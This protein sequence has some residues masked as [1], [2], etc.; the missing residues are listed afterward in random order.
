MPLRQRGE[1]P[2]TPLRRPHLWQLRR[3][4]HLWRMAAAVADRAG[5]ISILSI[6]NDHG[7][8][9]PPSVLSFLTAT[10]SRQPLLAWTRIDSL[11]CLPTMFRSF[12]P[13]G[14]IAKFT[15]VPVP[16]IH[17]SIGA[18][19]LPKNSI[20]ALPA[21]VCNLQIGSLVCC[22]KGDALTRRSLIATKMTIPRRR[23]NSAPTTRRALL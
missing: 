21:L 14:L 2:I 20:L 5:F 1:H 12:A 23:W 8:Y 4:P 17:Q 7:V 3:Q 22:C 16:S 15:P 9:P 19:I 6:D 11:R 13:L 18:R 10:P